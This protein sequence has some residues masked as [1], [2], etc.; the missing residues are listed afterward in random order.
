MT[1]VQVINAIMHQ[2]YYIGAKKKDTGE[3]IHPTVANK[4]D[5][6]ICPGCEKDVIL[7]KGEKRVHHFR[8][9]ADSNPC[10]LYNHPGESQIHKYAKLT[11]KHLIEE[12]KIKFTRE[13]VGCNEVCEI[14]FPEIIEDSRIT[15]EHRFTYKENL[16]IADVAHIIN[17]EIKAIFEVCHNIKQ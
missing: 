13:C 1:I 8:H 17:G 9:K 11:L 7:V 3:F 12:K 15:L 5:Q 2:Q 16:R 4:T 14:I 6:H 10:N